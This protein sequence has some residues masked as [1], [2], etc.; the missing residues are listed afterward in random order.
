MPG[1]ATRLS[2]GSAGSRFLNSQRLDF[3]VLTLHPWQ[4]GNFPSGHRS[5]VS[6]AIEWSL[7]AL[8]YVVAASVTRSHHR[9]RS[10]PTAPSRAANEVEISI[11]ADPVDVEQLGQFSDEAR[12]DPAVRKRLPFERQYT[13][14]DRL[15]IGEPNECPFCS[16]PHVDQNGTLIVFE[17]CPSL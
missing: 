1:L 6:L 9:L 5:S 17:L 4:A 2:V 7:E 13:L 14:P 12:I 15:Q 10:H 8:R 3:A 16:R 11:F